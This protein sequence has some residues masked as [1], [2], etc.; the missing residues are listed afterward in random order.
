MRRKEE[1]TQKQQPQYPLAVVSFGTADWMQ[2]GN[3]SIN[4]SME[5][6]CMVMVVPWLCV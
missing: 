4:V 1:A 3:T 6:K 5:L 2:K